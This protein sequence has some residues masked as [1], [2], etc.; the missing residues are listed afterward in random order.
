MIPDSVR[1]DFPALGQQV[2]GH[3]LVYLD[4][5]A[6]TLK[7]QSVIDAINLHY[8]KESANVHRGVHFLSEQGTVKYEETRHTVQKFINALSEREII[9]TKGTTE[10]INLV[11]QC[12]GQQV[13]KEGDEILLSTMEHHSN[14]VPWQLVAE[15]TGAVIKVVP[16]TDS[17]EIELE[18]YSQL[19]NEKTKIVSISYISNTLGSINP[20]KEMI[21]L[22]HEKG[23]L[24]VVD[25]AQAMAHIPVDVVDLDC[26]FLAFSAHK[27]FGPTGVGV[28]YGKE[29]LLESMPPYQGGG[30]MIETVTF[31]KTT[32]NQLPEKFE[33]GTPHI[34][35]VI[36]LKD[37]ID[38]IQKV[39]LENIA[40]KEDQLLD[41]AT[42]RLN[43]ISGLK[44]IGTAKKK[45]AVISFTLEG[46][47][48]HDLGTL[49]DQQGIAIRTGHHCT[50]PL[51]KR[52]GITATA[53]ASFSFYNTKE[54][55]D[56]LVDGIRKAQ[57]LL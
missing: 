7:S 16:I 48:P 21:E 22:A 15:K 41:Y 52:F 19:L 45:S 5:A 47:H 50:Q 51:M 56:K 9:F 49:L 14:I 27:M 4:N 32:Y 24:F 25:A 10:S 34:A 11:A 12:L 40:E 55:V 23:A 46:A 38:Y 54:E 43:M 28:L 36:A 30:A 37:C 13:L 53:R 33:A 26:D 3:P 8:Q 39:G 42:Q 17:G 44:L 29:S 6:T 20:I 35:G 31:E 57:E 2:H 18:A 1:S